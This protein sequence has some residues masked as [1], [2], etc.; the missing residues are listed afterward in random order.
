MIVPY[1]VAATTEVRTL[2]GGRGDVG[3]V[4]VVAPSCAQKTENGEGEEDA[5]GEAGEEAGEDGGDRELGRLVC[6][7]DR[8]RREICIR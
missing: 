6:I 4:S 7:G 8:E 1:E 3:F 2:E 5:Q